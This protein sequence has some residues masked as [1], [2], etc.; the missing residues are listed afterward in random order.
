M[1]HKHRLVKQKEKNRKNQAMI[2]KFENNP[3]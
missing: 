2:P 3:I 1:Q